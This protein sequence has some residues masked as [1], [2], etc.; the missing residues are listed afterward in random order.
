[1]HDTEPRL[2]MSEREIKRFLFRVE[3]FQ[4]HGW[5]EER[6]EAWADKLVNRDRDGDDRRLC[7]ECQNLLSDWRCADKGAV[8]A[9]LLQRCP[10]F[11]W[12]RP[13]G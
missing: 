1:M 5:P 7:V 11:V 12:A 2:A 13:K 8:V 6:A 10:S 9:D 3:L 4:Q